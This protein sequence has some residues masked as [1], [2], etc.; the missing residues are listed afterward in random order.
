VA[1]AILLTAGALWLLVAVAGSGVALVGVDRL[2]GLLPPL[3]I[4]ADAVAGTVAALAIAAALVGVAHLVI[5][6]GLRRDRSW[7]FSAG[8]LLAAGAAVAF[9][10]L[11]AAALT[12]GVAGTMTT[13]GAVGA[14]IG[15]AL[16]AAAYG[17]AAAALVGRMR[18]GGPV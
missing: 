13:I 6:G 4:D 11:A 5:A 12:S 2:L 3:A 16:A 17:V 8:I 18:T 1:R 7:A 10:A 9:L 14:A 15:A